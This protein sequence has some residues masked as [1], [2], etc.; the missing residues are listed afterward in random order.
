MAVLPATQ[1]IS[2]HDSA[3]TGIDYLGKSGAISVKKKQF[4]TT[5]P[6]ARAKFAYVP[7][8]ASIGNM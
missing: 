6:P 1:Y 4:A 2:E 3:A 7:K 8:R 5:E